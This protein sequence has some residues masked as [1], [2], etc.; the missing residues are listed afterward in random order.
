MRAAHDCQGGAGL[1][2]EWHDLIQR[3]L[4]GTLTE[5]ETSALQQALASDDTL[6]RIY[7]DYV[8][9]DVALAAKAE[10]E[11]ATRELITASASC[12]VSRWRPWHRFAAAAVAGLLLG[13]ISGS[14]VYGFII[15]RQAAKQSAVQTLLTEGFE[16][17]A[18]PSDPGLPRRA[19][20]W[21][22]DFRIVDG[23]DEKLTPAEGRYMALLSP[24]EKRKFSYAS[25]FLDVRAFSGS[26][27]QQSRQIEMTARF[28]GASP[29]VR[30]R[31]QIRLAAFADD[32]AAAREIWIAG[33]VNEQALLHVSK[34]ITTDANFTGWTTLRS[35]I[36]LPPG[37]RYVLLSLAAG[38]A[39]S[40][41][42][43][44]VHYLDDIQVR[45]ITR[46]GPP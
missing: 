5:D 1:N 46:S 41:A 30:D 6:R 24:V 31:Y 32:V 45:L 16:D 27:A 10:G 9:L 11:I 19:G 22:G 36:D 3:R 7:L 35:T 26:E 20:V 29:G 23:A 37:A 8:N 18:M 33:N 17:K 38:V 40:N 34:S 13:S 4:S 2:T 25:R 15:Q 39:D 44:T 21:S 42:Q 28:H 14:M 12:P 43:K